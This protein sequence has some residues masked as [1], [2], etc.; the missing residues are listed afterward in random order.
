MTCTEP[1]RKGHFVPPKGPKS[2]ENAQNLP[3]SGHF[4]YVCAA[5]IVPARSAGVSPAR[6]RSGRTACPAPAASPTPR[7]PHRNLPHPSPS[8]TLTTPPP[9]CIVKE[10]V[11]PSGHSTNP[12][13]PRPAVAPGIREE[14][15]AHDNVCPRR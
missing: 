9:P 4:S 6:P 15:D 7:P 14:R 2:P 11:G 1:P 12:R 10:L 3:E 13:S 5:W 8:P